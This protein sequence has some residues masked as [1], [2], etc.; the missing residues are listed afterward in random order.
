MG[1]LD[2]AS[3][4]LLL[5]TNDGDLAHK[6]THASSQVRKTYLIKVSKRPSE[7]N[8]ARLRGGVSIAVG[9]QPS[10]RTRA[11]AVTVELVKDAENPWYEVTLIEGRNRQIRKM[12]EEI[13]HHV[14]KIKRVRY[15]S[16]ELDVSPGTFR[17]LSAKEVS[18][19][20]G[21]VSSALTGKLITSLGGPTPFGR[22]RDLDIT[23][24]ANVAHPCT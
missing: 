17:R 7:E 8:I 6:L 23:F 16:L 18:A 24:D 19:L 3:E 20:K 9:R 10:Q 5:L 14:E 15:G 2:Y 11:A 13:G 22:S 1:R 12:F 4:G 21:Q